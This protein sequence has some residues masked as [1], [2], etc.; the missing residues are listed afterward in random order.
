MAY[1][2]I[3]ATGFHA[4]TYD[5]ILADRLAKYRSIYGEDIYLE[6][7]GQEY[8]MLAMDALAIK[9]VIDLAESVYKSFSPSTAVGAGLSS[10]VK[11]NGIA[12]Q[13]ATFST[14]DVVLTCV[15]GTVIA[16]GV[17]EDVAGRRWDLPALVTADEDG[18]A[19]ATATA[20]EAGAVTAA[21][22]DVATIATPTRGWL[23]VTNPAAAVTGVEG[24]KDAALRRRQA[25]S[26]ALPSKTVLEG[27]IGAVA[28]VNGVTRYKGYENDKDVADENGL[29]GHSFAI[30]VEGGDSEAIA[31]AI[32]SKKGPGPTTVGTSSVVV[33]D[34]Y[35]A[36]N[37]IRFYRVTEVALTATITIQARS[38]YVS[39]T[40]AAI[41]TNVAAHANGLAI[42][43]DVLLSKLYT[44]I[45][46]AEP[47]TA[48]TFDVLSITLARDGGEESAANVGIDFNEAA[49]IA[50]AD[51][52]LVVE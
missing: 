45:N 50:A 29:P 2:Y 33:R 38:G 24:E 43:E 9:D 19:T 5:E 10:N 42:G 35:D 28:D 3:D 34:K 27:I 11:L 22:G 18:L 31:A 52:V 48:R 46:E 23:A 8:Q 12:R 36:P 6:A 14:V 21:P 16:D 30:V 20:Q 25:T 51:I 15:A 41:V 37:T 39:T 44:P 32:A 7:D 26:T 1:A 4:S 17:V 40:G 47:S 13:S 49:V